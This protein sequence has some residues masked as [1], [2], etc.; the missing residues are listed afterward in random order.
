MVLHFIL[1]FI[2][3]YLGTLTPSMLNMTAAKISLNKSKKDAIR[4]AIGVSIV[5][6]LQAYIAILF[7]KF[8]RANPDFVQALQKIAAVIFIILSFYFYRQSKKEKDPRDSVKEKAGNSFVG[9]LLLSAL[10][11]FSIPFYCGV[12]TALDIAGWFQFSQKNILVFVIGSALGTFVLLFMYANYAELIQS[13]SKVIAK[14]L[15][16]IL[17]ILTGSLALLTFINLLY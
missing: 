16:L 6:L 15:N 17:S 2:T 9:G 10:N 1:G 8:L 13:K 7:T 14:N 4:F 11:M 12:T 3:S 5:V